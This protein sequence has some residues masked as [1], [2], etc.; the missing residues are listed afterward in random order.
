MNT[1]S[2]RIL[3]VLVAA[4]LAAPMAV[5][6]GSIKGAVKFEG[7]RPKRTVVKMDADP[8]CAKIHGDKKVGSEEAIVSKDGQV[9]NAFIYIKSGLTGTF[10]APETAATIDQQGCMYTP[11]V[12]G[13]M[14]DQKLDIKNSDN[15]LH[16]IHCLAKENPEFNFGQPTPG[17]RDKTFRKAEIGVKFK[18]DVHPWMGAWIHVM[19]HPF[20]A[21]SDEAGAFEI[22]DVPDGEYTVGVWHETLG[23]TEAKVTVAGGEIVQDFTLKK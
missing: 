18:C 19:E 7:E 16:N 23:E 1:I 21:T 20:F 9:K 12:Q 8:N 11:H 13:I 15:T 14:V 3:A 22:K 2:K 4:A 10:K 17:V 6:A 5:S